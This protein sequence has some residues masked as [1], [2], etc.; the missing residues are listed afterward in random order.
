M[1]TISGP[2][3]FYPAAREIRYSPEV[4]T[5]MVLKAKDTIGSGRLEYDIAH[6]GAPPSTGCSTA[7]HRNLRLDAHAKSR[8]F[9]AA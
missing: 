9:S 8:T 7:S 5:A 4:K 2:I 1:S 3:A 6:T